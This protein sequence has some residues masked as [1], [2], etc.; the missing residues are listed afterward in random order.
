MMTLNA[1]LALDNEK[2]ELTLTDFDSK[3]IIFYDKNELTDI[4][5]GLFLF[6]K[7]KKFKSI[8]S[9]PDHKNI[10]TADTMVQIIPPQT[11]DND[12]LKQCLTNIAK[13]KSLPE[14]TEVNEPSQ[15]EMYDY[16]GKLL[17]LLEKFGFTF[18]QK[19]RTPAKAQHRWKKTLSE[20]EFFVDDFHSQA[21]VI[22]QKRNEFLIKKGAHLRPSY[23][24]NKDGSVGLGARMGT[25]LRDEQKD[26]IQNFITTED[27]ILKS[28]NEVGLFLY[29]GGTNSWLVLKDNNGQTIDEWSKVKK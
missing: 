9:T 25:Q 7:D 22:W 11:L 1:E 13:G 28:V 19:K 4:K 12:D 10:P 29:F 15:V 17:L 24:L 3:V 8:Q 16:L 5:H 18:T 6:F 23:S 27:I 14:L 26:K 21:T 2:A 20:I